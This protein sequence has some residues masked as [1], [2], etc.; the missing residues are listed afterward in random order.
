MKTIK[1]IIEFFKRIRIY[2][3]YEKTFN[4]SLLVLWILEYDVR[5][6]ATPNLIIFGFKIWKLFFNIYY[7]YKEESK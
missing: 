1:K 5:H 4:P 3:R 6:D 7:E 2:G